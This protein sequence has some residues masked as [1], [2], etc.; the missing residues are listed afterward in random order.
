MW[1]HRQQP[2][3]L[4]RPWDSPGKNT[5]VGC[6]LPLQCMKVKSESEVAQ[7]CPTLHN[8][9]DSSHQVP[10][11]MEF[12]RQEYWSEVPSPSPNGFP[13]FLHFKSEFCNK[14]FMIWATVSFWSCFCW[15][16]R[17]SPSGCKEYNQ[18]DFGVDHLVM[19]KCRVF[20]C[21]VG[22][23]C[24]LWPV[25]SLGKTLLAFAL[26]LLYSKAKFACYSRCF[27]TSYFCIPVPYNEKDI[28]FGC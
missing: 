25:H 15:L 1:P 3:S 27:L 10:L 7:S 22:R 18:S 19:F 24:L 20:S 6:H 13:Y 11:F 21:V 9:M 17:A 5:G 28:C 8:P 2:T 4:W 14:E 16:Y 26:L 23:G 12:S